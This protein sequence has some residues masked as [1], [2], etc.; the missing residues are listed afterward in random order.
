LIQDKRRPRSL[1][2]FSILDLAAVYMRTTITMRLV[3]MFSMSLGMSLAALQPIYAQGAVGDAVSGR[4]YASHWCI[5]CHSIEP[6]TEGAG[7]APD[8][9]AIAKSRSINALSLKVFLRSTHNL[10]PDFILTLTE[11]DDIVAYILSLK[12]K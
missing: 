12:R 6:A 4:V 3:A 8:F 5:E 1:V 11:T 10:M 7:F 9:T 2:Y